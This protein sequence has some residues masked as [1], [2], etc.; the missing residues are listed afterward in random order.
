MKKKYVFTPKT[1]S[2]SV[3]QHKYA[4]IKLYKQEKNRAPKSM[5]IRIF[6]VIL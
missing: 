5:K 2:T 3:L 4:D 1:D 6:V